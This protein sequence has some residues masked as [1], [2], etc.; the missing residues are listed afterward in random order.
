MSD[1]K[2]VGSPNHYDGRNGYAISHITLH[3]MVGYLTGTDSV[4]Q[5]AGGA[6]AHYGIGGNG[7]IHQYVSESDGSWSDANFASNNSTVSIEHEG[8]MPACLARARAWT[9]RPACVPRSPAAK[10]G[11]ACGTTGATATC[12][13]TGRYPAPTTT[14]APTRP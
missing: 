10:A 14:G 6:S 8:G 2:W 11:A 9:L 7:E 13:C 4:F 1:I 12:G 5:R 3:I